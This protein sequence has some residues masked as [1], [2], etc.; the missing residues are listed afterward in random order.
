MNNGM[1]LVLDFG[2]GLLM[3]AGFFGGLW[4]TINKAFRVGQPALWFLASFL[5]RMGGAVAGFYFV[6]RGEPDRLAFCVLGFLLARAVA[7]RLKAAQGPS[8]V[9]PDGKV[10][11]CS[12]PASGKEISGEDVCT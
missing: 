12:D 9:A 1:I 8:S 7:T 4:W 5:L 11:S 6:S 3:G 2:A 10:G